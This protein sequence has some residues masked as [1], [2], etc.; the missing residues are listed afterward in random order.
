MSFTP[1][2]DILP[3]AQRAFWPLLRE[4]PRHFVLYGGTALA[5]R[6]GHRQSVDFDFFTS[7]PFDP[8]ELQRSLAFLRDGSLLQLGGHTLSMVVGA[9]KNVN[10]SFFGGLDNLGRVKNPDLTDD[11]VVLVA[12]LL[13]VAACKAAVV[14]ERAEAKDYRD[15]YAL[16]KSGV[17]LEQMLAAAE[18]VYGDQYGAAITLKSL[19]YFEDGNLKTL[20]RE[21]K[22]TLSAA[23]A[24]IGEIPKFERQP[25][26]LSPVWSSGI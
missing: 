7:E 5:L 1:N 10:I 24:N 18:A 19:T 26:G 16:L 11:G 13:D 8:R 9:D 23:A 12:S 20:P 3:R 17:S 15:I 6:L 21:V 4:V 2:L 22:E 14:Y 25:G